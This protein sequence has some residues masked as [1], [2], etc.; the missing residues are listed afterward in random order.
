MVQQQQQAAA[1]GQVST[2]QRMAPGVDVSPDM[3]SSPGV[4]RAAPVVGEDKIAELRC[5]LK[6]LDSI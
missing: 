5:A 4:K 3:P 6:T 1:Q 2:L